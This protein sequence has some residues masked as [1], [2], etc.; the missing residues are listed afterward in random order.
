MRRLWEPRGVAVVGA[1]ATP[2]AT[3]NRVLRFLMAHG[4]AGAVYPVHPRLTE[5]EGLP[6]YP[7]V[8]AIPGPVDLA[9]IA[10][11]AERARAV[12]A[13]CAAKG[14]A[15]AVIFSSGFGETGAPGQA[16]EAELAAFARTYGIRLL[17]PNC[18]GLVSPAERLVAGFSPLFAS[19]QFQPG[20]IGLVAQSG[21]LGFGI[22]SLAIEQGLQFSRIITTGNEA[23]LTAAELVRELLL[24]EQTEVVLVY[25]EGLKAAPLWREVGALSRQVGKP[26]IILKAGRS[27]GGARAATSHTAAMAG[28]DQVWEAAFRQL[29]LF[30]VEDVDEMLDLA[31]VF[32]AAKRPSGKRVGVL[33]T[34]GGAGILATDAL[35]HLGLQ[36]PSLTEG[37]RAT[38]SAIVPAFGSVTNPVDVTAQVIGD[39]ALFRRSLAALVEDPGIDLL[40]V[41]FCV[42]QGAEA[43]R[44]VD[45]MLSVRSAKPILVARTGAEG[46]APRAAER[47]RLG[48][49][50]VFR[51]PGRAAR[52]A[53]ALAQF[54]AAAGG[55]EG[56]GRS[57]SGRQPDEVRGGSEPGDAVGSEGRSS[58]E[59]L[60][61]GPVGSAGSS[62]E[63]PAVN[64]WPAPGGQL[65]ERAVKALL[66]AEGLPVTRERSVVSSDE[67][68][69]AAEEIGYP[70]VLKLD[71]PEVAHKTEVGGV[72]LNLPDATA[73]RGAFAELRAA[74]PDAPCLV[75]EMVTDDVAEVLVGVTPSP[76]GPVITVGS[77]GV[78]T[79]VWQ[80]VTR[81][82]APVSTAEALQM[83]QELKL[84]RVLTGFRG[85]PP[86]DLEALTKLIARV[87]ELAVTWPGAWELDLN[88]VLARPQGCIIADGLL[89]V[90][91]G[92]PC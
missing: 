13:D 56:P 44:V 15:Y 14:V 67:A 61:W 18:I 11:G 92:R 74:I 21:A 46:L 69:V 20:R 1:S 33:T 81:R 49:I 59:G 76:I 68:V 10:V 80:D 29:G 66:R 47:L 8:D 4:F 35:E 7:S 60:P 22:A 38:L 73:V 83:L 58:S 5:V 86:A 19:A 90:K 32:D 3:G 84:W 57:P 52:A 82:L 28:D 53:A 25:A 30:R 89:V 39:P 91:E 23:D 2:G 70:V 63:Q 72:K 71:S 26:V 40:Q 6:C 87:S 42:L 24:D 16:L 27:E 41:C 9:L 88:P 34:S 45:D 54:A 17:G 79:E 51:S 36:V 43:E 78:M 12:L 48:G 65:S 77:G 85:R 55:T 31:A 62:A 37:T 75:Q 64:G 50:P